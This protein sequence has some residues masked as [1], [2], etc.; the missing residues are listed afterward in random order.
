MD[1]K[2]HGAKYPDELSGGEQ[3]RIALARA[4]A[5]NPKLLLLDEPFSNLDTALKSQIRDELFEI[6]K[7]TGI[8]CIFV[9]HDVNDAILLANKMAV[10]DQGKVIQMGTPKKNFLINLQRLR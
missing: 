3:Q 6:I 10:V 5:P 9:T 4:L 8:S 1:W 2:S 7:A